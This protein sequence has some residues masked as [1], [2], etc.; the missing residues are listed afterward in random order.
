[1][2]VTKFVRGDLK[3]HSSTPQHVQ[4]PTSRFLPL[5]SSQTR[6]LSFFLSF[7]LRGQTLHVPRCAMHAPTPA[8]TNSR[9]KF[10][11]PPPLPRLLRSFVVLHPTPLR[12][13]RRGRR[14]GRRRRRR[15]S[16]E[17]KRRRVLPYLEVYGQLGVATHVQGAVVKMLPRALAVNRERRKEKR[18]TGNIRKLE[19]VCVCVCVKERERVCVR[20]S[21]CL[22]A[23]IHA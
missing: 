12:R 10:Q 1:M 6:S 5:H 23:S 21:V 7:F 18:R 3:K 8:S 9:R 15:K 22:S 19:V 16:I 13:R 11:S 2:Q 4:S 17:Q 20:V 14:R